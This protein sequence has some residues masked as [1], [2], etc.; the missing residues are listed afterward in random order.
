MCNILQDL[1]DNQPGC[2]TGVSHRFLDMLDTSD[3]LGR[4]VEAAEYTNGA[5]C[6]HTNSVKENERLYESS[7]TKPI[8][9]LQS[10]YQMAIT[11]RN[12]T[13]AKEM[14]LK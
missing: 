3:I 6:R 4:P 14:K 9:N 7:I 12:V 13:F 1:F 5:V 10:S 2:R 8:D 11:S